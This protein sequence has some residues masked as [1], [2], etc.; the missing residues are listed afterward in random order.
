MSFELTPKERVAILSKRLL[1][2]RKGAGEYSR[3][4]RYEEISKTKDALQE[5]FVDHGLGCK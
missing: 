5:A 3:S 2:L 4:A 1:N